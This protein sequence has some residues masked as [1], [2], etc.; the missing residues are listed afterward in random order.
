[1]QA[2]PVDAHVQSI[3]TYFQQPRSAILLI[4]GFASGLPLALTSGTLQAWMTVE[5]IDLKTIGFFSLVGQAY[6]FKFLW[7]PLMDRYTPPFLGGDAV[8]CSP[9]KSCY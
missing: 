7:S 3:F 8:G 6:V 9:R 2:G 5:N 1:M 4:L